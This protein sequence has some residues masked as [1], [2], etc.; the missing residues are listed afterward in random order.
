MGFEITERKIVQVS[1]NLTN[2][3][4]TSIFR[5]F[6][7]IKNEAERYGISV[8]GSEIVGL[9][10]LEAL[11]DVTDHYLRLENFNIDQILEK[12]LLESKK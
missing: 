3:Q 11:A 4:K 12:K 6:E 5:V 10:P 7:T 9:I 2:Y 8:I 1:M